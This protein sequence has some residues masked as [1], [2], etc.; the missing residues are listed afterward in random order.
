MTGAGL[1]INSG[2]RV[3][4][5]PRVSIVD[6][7]NFRCLYRGYWGRLPSSAPTAR[8]WVPQARILSFEETERVMCRGTGPGIRKVW[9]AGREPLP[10]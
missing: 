3:L 7:C 6:R 10:R 2:S 5:D 1:L 9:L 8:Q 4:R